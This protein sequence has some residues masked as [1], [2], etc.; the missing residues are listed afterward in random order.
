M[1]VNRDSDKERERERER[2]RDRDGREEGTNSLIVWTYFIFKKINTTTDIS[3]T[4]K[5]DTNKDS[6]TSSKLASNT[7]HTN[8]KTRERGR[9]DTRD[10]HSTTDRDRRDSDYFNSK[11][12][13]NDT[14]RA[15]PE[16]TTP[17]TPS[18]PSTFKNDYCQH[19]VDTKQRPQNFIRDSDLADRFEE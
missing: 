10:K 19:F 3:T 2:E 7:K 5:T 11:D 13:T 15:T 14:P 12:K 9:Q 17:S 8:D 1:Y 4:Q 16:K 6:T 18:A